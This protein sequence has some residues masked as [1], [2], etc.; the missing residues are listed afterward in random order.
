MASRGAQRESGRGG[1]G[2]GG[3]A[4]GLSWAGA[5]GGA[6]VLLFSCAVGRAATLLNDTWADGSRAENNL[7]TES[8]VHAG[9]SG[10]DGGSLTTT[11]GA[12]QN[13]MG[14]GSRK[15]WTYFTS[16]NSAPDG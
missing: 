6:A 11:T 4:R 7:P 16:D 12:L 8:A 9:V 13:V 2:R 3:S 10:T 1:S 5:I 14:T 15:I